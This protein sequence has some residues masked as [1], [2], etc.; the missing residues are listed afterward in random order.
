M[1]ATTGTAIIA[2]LAAAMPAAVLLGTFGEV[3]R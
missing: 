2:R 1:L 3:P